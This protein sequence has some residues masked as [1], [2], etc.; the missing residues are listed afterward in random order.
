[1]AVRALGLLGQRLKHGPAARRFHHAL[2][3]G[4]GVVAWVATKADCD[5]LQH[6]RLKMTWI[7][8]APAQASSPVFFI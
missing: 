8:V 4:L 6:Q 2:L 5:K 3:V 1:M 7:E